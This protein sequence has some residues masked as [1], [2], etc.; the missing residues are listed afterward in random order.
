MN[1]E[2]VLSQQDYYNRLEHQA[3]MEILANSE[4]L[5]IFSILKPKFGVDEGRYFVL[6]GDDLQSG[7][8][9]FGETLILAIRDFNGQFYKKANP[10]TNWISSNNFEVVKNAV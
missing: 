6:L 2:Q 4:D 3:K 8:C 1:E 9:G 5:N 7:I 10:K